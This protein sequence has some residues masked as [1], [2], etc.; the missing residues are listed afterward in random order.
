ML[1]LY[2]PNL[3]D[4]ILGGVGVRAEKDAPFVLGFEPFPDSDPGFVH[5]THRE[6]DT[7]KVAG[8]VA[9]PGVVP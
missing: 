1:A 3:Y 8:R 9:C 5:V 4:L 6:S 7:G 2:A